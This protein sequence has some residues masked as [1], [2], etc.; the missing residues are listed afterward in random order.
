MTASNFTVV[1]PLIGVENLSPEPL[2]LVLSSA[3]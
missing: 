3:E 1:N 2:T